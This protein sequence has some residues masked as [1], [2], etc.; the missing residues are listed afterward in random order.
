MMSNGYFVYI[1]KYIV[2]WINEEVWY[3]DLEGDVWYLDIIILYNLKIYIN[4]WW[5]SIVCLNIIIML[6]IE[7]WMF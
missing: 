4:Y 7:Y 1:Y 6:F 2:V 5:F 3:V